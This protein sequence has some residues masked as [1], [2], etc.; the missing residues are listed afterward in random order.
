MKKIRVF[1]KARSYDIVIGSDLIKDCGALLKNLKIGKD[2]VVI[3]NR[4]VSKLYKK[5][6]ENS[7]EKSGLKV[8]FELVPASEKA[9]SGAVATRLVNR[10][11]AYD[12][13]K[14]IF[15]VAFGGGV[16]GDLAGFVASIYKRGVPYVQIPTT[17]LAQ[18][19]SAIG[20]KVAIDLSIAKNLIGAFY[21]PKMVLSDAS[22]LKS[23]STRQIRNG[24]AEII[25][26]GII[27][28]RHLFEYLERNYKK[29][30][31]LDK[32]ALEF[33]IAKSSRI[34]ARIVETDEFDNKGRR[35]IL[36]Y[37]HT[38][39]HA[40]EAASGYSGRF[41][42]GEAISIGMVGAALISMRLGLMKREDALRIEMLVSHAGLPTRIKGLKF[43]RIYNALLHDKKFTHR[44]NRFILPVGIGSVKA[45]EG[46]PDSIIKDVIRGLFQ[47]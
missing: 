24:L 23:L 37:G 41:Y 6:L 30:L 7:L 13:Y 33:I 16:V 32:K 22:L 46:V 25:K 11:S 28:D 12:R 40:I 27:K 38:I 19:D 21:Q 15:I 5:P 34:K 45:V 31:N 2:A 29:V 8:H 20:G 17:L 44:K 26:Y 47:R 39:G 18:V 14:E 9:K 43:S 36:N 35:V 1:L 4:P 3:T 42:H 10:I